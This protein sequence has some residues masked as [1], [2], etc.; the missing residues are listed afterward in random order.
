MN[1]K[2]HSNKKYFKNKAAITQLA[3]CD[4]CKVDVGCAIHPGGTKQPF[5][6]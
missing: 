4:P 2:I 5:E 1:I 3:E 6:L